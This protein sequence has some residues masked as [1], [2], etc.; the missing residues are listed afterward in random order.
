M[1]IS[2]SAQQPVKPLLT[3]ITATWCPNCG[4]WGWTAM[5]DMVDRFDGDK[6]TVMALHYS[7]DLAD[8]LNKELAG[9]FPAV[10]QPIFQSNGTD[11]NFTSSS[12]TDKMD[13]LESTIN[14]ETQV[15][16]AF[17]ITKAGVHL[18]A[19]GNLTTFNVEVNVDADNLPDGDYSIGA[20]IVRD[21]IVASQ[22]GLSGDVAHFKIVDAAMS[23]NTFGNPYGI[24]KSYVFQY[25]EADYGE[26][27]FDSQGG[28]EDFQIVTILWNN[29][30]TRYEVVTT[31][32][33]NITENTLSNIDQEVTPIDD[34]KVYENT[35]NQIEVNLPKNGVNSTTTLANLYTITG[36]QLDSQ[37]IKDGK[38]YFE[39]ESL[40]GRGL[41]IVT[42]ESAGQLKSYK[43][44]IK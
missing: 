15:I 26:I 31:D 1:S 24:A 33:A 8:D 17:N 29:T 18:Q 36:R 4:T 44:T 23:I 34:A 32:N 19:E 13:A 37:T 28:V 2:L 27:T 11:L 7:G 10:G 5:K 38:A 14:A 35:A 42:L 20:Y 9:N 3:K 30:G 25:E 16:N 40:L 21:D 6:A 43:V 41:Y 22:S 39:R 12:Y